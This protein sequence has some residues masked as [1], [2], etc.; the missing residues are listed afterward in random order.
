MRA[1][2]IARGLTPWSYTIT[3][4]FPT[5]DQ[6]TLISIVTPLLKEIQSLSIPLAPSQHNSVS[7]TN[8]LVRIIYLETMSTETSR[9][10]LIQKESTNHTLTVISQLLLAGATRRKTRAVDQSVSVSEKDQLMRDSDAMMALVNAIEKGGDPAV[11]RWDGVLT[12]I[13]GRKGIVFEEGNTWM[14]RRHEMGG[15]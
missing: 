15:V 3:H 9:S 6:L 10:A 12:V 1:E 13:V 5:A 8:D 14:A 11:N 2:R 4:I 7:W